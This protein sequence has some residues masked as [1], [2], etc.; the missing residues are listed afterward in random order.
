M[1]QNGVFQNFRGAEP[2]VDPPLVIFNISISL[3][4]NGGLGGQSPPRLAS[5]GLGFEYGVFGKCPEALDRKEQGGNAI[6]GTSIASASI[7]RKLAIFCACAKN[8]A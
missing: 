4:S 6:N 8:V 2:P 5:D 3:V 1:D 7:R